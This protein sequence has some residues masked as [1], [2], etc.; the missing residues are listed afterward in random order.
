MNL[1][2]GIFLLIPKPVL[3]GSNTRYIGDALLV[4]ET[5]HCHADP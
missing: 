5:I 2:S 1:V 3:T 4:A